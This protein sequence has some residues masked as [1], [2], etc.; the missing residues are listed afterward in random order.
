VPKIN[1]YLPDELATAVRDAAIPVSAVCQRALEDALR[2]ATALREGQRSD[3]A[4][5]PA[6]VRLS[7]R[8]TDRLVRSLGLAF[9]AARSRSHGFVGTEH[10]LLGMLDEEENLGVRVIDAME[11]SPADVRTELDATMH[12]E[13]RDVPA[14]EPRLAMGAERSLTLMSEEASNLRHNYLGCEHLLLGLIAEQDGIAGRVLRTLGLDLVVTRRAVMSALTGF[15]HARANSSAGSPSADQ[16]ERL[17]RDIATRL[18]G[19]ES[20]LRAA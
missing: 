2:A 19:I 20:Q 14:G 7:G 8:P 10:L 9:Q 15:I 11:V 3:R 4:A 13:L 17:L 12:Q 6:G 5:L 16:L 1:V 18:T